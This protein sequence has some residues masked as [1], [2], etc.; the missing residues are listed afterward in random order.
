[1]KVYSVTV[2]SDK[3]VDGC[4]YKGDFGPTTLEQLRERVEQRHP[5]WSSMV[6]VVTR[7]KAND[8]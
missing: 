2:N 6:I 8:L 5:T 7:S 3:Y 4:D 1:M